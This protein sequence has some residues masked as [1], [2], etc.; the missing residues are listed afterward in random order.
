MLTIVD[1]NRV[2]VLR[3]PFG[4]VWESTNQINARVGRAAF[5]PFVDPLSGLFQPL[6][7]PGSVFVQLANL[8]V[9]AFLDTVAQS[10]DA[11]RNETDSGR[12]DKNANG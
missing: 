3:R 9:Q 10:T 12:H 6:V 2:E 8:C 7:P 11:T 5:V 4:H 1:R